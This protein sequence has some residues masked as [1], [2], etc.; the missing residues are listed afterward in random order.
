[1][2]ELL[3]EELAPAYRQMSEDKAREADALEWSEATLSDA[4]DEAA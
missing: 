1:M 4:T 2:E 3:P